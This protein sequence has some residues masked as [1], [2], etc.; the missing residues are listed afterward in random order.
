MTSEHTLMR[1]NQKTQQRSK[2]IKQ[3]L[4][5]VKACEKQL[6]RIV[7]YYL[8]SLSDEKAP[9]FGGLKPRDFWTTC[10]AHVTTEIT[11][12]KRKLENA[13]ANTDIAFCKSELNERYD[14]LVDLETLYSGNKS[15]LLIKNALIFTTICMVLVMS[16]LAL[17]LPLFFIASYSVLN[18]GLLGLGFSMAKGAI[19]DAS[20]VFSKSLLT[21]NEKHPIFK[22]YVYHAIHSARYQ[23]HGAFYDLPVNTIEQVFTAAFSQYGSK[24]HVVRDQKFSRDLK[25]WFFTFN[26]REIDDKAFLLVSQ[27]ILVDLKAIHESRLSTGSKSLPE[28]ELPACFTMQQVLHKKN[29]KQKTKLLES[30]VAEPSSSVATS[31]SESQD[32]IFPEEYRYDGSPDCRVKPI[33]NSYSGSYYFV[34]NIP[35]NSF[36]SPEVERKFK[37]KAAQIA[38]RGKDGQGVK[39]LSSRYI[40]NLTSLG[41]SAVQSFKPG[42]ARVKVLGNYSV[43]DIGIFGHASVSINKPNCHLIVFDTVI[44]NTHGSKR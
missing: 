13:T 8:A 38:T 1:P 12:I 23:L 37:E 30:A 6:S 18:A 7:I 14:F 31:S 22:K 33:G 17:T 26:P 10:L 41:V 36:S 16:A 2:D 34:W 29:K 39:F 43:G 40:E 27:Q 42:D 32:I 15:P 28:Q 19:E 3:A 25:S 5:Y 9:L 11:E 35:P 21:F 20:A 4:A 24:I 44:D